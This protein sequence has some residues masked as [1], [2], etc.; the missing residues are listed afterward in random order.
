M[1]PNYYASTV[2]PDKIRRVKFFDEENQKYIVV[3][4]NNFELKA[5][6]IAQLY[7]YR[8]KIELFF[9]WIK[10]HLKIKSFWGT[11]INAV[12]IQ[13]YIAII[14]YT[15]VSIIKSKL[16]LE[17]STYEILQILGFSLID[18]TS[19]NELLTNQDYQN[20]KELNSNQLNIF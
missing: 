16:K 13:V 15:L 7:R 14:T 5:E 2:Y 4:T 1:L 6:D 11:S 3:F 17:K 8:W 9:R 18:K 12:K 20:V 19:I 10:Q